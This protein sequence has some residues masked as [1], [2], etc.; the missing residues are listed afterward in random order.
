MFG[1][2]HSS[3]KYLAQQLRKNFGPKFV[4]TVFGHKHFFT[5]EKIKQNQNLLDSTLFI[6]IVRNPYSWLSGMYDLPYHCSIFNKKNKHI[7]LTSE[8][9]SKND[10]GEIIYEDRHI[11]HKNKY[12]NIFELRSTKNIFLKYSMPRL[13]PH[14][15]FIKYEFF[16]QPNY[17]N[18]LIYSIAHKYNVNIIDYHQK[19]KIFNRHLKNFGVF[20]R[21]N[22]PINHFYSKEILDLVNT[23][24]DWN[25]ENALGYYPIYS[26][27]QKN[28]D[29][30]K[31]NPDDYLLRKMSY[32]IKDKT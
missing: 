4:V 22:K 7:F 1:E 15:M 27:D 10:T 17:L 18:F 23:N 25:I 6:A 24:I 13:V 9:E 21:G 11:F 19:N 2:R 28:T 32:G 26:I 5:T 29:L 14:Y 31:I 30:T 16:L 20:C 3:T 12:K 8:W